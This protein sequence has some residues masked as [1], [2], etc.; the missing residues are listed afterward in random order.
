MVADIQP[1]LMQAR[2]VKIRNKEYRMLELQ[3][4]SADSGIFSRSISE[5]TDDPTLAGNNSHSRLDSRLA[6]L[7][8]KNEDDCDGQQR[9]RRHQMNPSGSSSGSNHKRLTKKSSKDSGIDCRT[10]SDSISSEANKEFQSAQ[11]LASDTVV[12]DGDDDEDDTTNGAGC[13]QPFSSLPDRINRL[14][15]QVNQ[16][17][18]EQQVDGGSRHNSKPVK[19]EANSSD[20]AKASVPEQ[21]QQ[22]QLPHNGHQAKLLLDDS[23]GS[24][25]NNNNNNNNNTDKSSDIEPTHH[26]APALMHET[27]LQEQSADQLDEFLIDPKLINR[28]DGLKRSYFITDENG[29][30]KILEDIIERELEKKNKKRDMLDGEADVDLFGC[31]GFSRLTKLIKK[32]RK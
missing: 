23:S 1:A 15:N 17:H 16:Q 11:N 18:D 29:S 32:G 12:A 13:Q 8:D 21:P 5:R 25:I 3:Q 7:T 9:L 22:Q 2:K 10:K 26:N 14:S 30:P 27:T 4:R 20:S 31:L 19:I 24:N 6:S 28:T